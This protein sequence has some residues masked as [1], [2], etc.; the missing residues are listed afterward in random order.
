M[1]RLLEVNQ[2]FLLYPEA[3]YATNVIFQQ[4]YGPY[5]TVEETKSDFSEK[6]HLYEL[7][8]EFFVLS[9]GP[10]ICHS[11]IYPCATADVALFRAN[12]NG[13]ENS[14]TSMRINVFCQI[15][16]RRPKNMQI[17]GCADGK[18][19]I[20]VRREIR[21]IIFTRKPPNGWLSAYQRECKQNI[22]SDR[23]IVEN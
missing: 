13:M 20:R 6:R 19:Y 2:Q 16:V 3:L 17:H 4:S 1:K 5:R 10:A 8:T 11:Y 23:I 14:Y 7:K 9:N 15:M 12:K 18:G 21:A 22:F